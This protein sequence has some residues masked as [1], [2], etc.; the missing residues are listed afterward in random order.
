MATDMWQSG[1]IQFIAKIEKHDISS[2]DFIPASFSLVNRYWK[3]F[4]FEIDHQLAYKEEFVP[5]IAR[6]TKRQKKAL[7]VFYGD[8]LK[9][10]MSC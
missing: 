9:M 10:K 2:V 5:L 6:K 4:N 8:H 3:S 7:T 1:M